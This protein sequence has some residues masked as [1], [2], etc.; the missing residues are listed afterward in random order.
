MHIS[1]MAIRYESVRLDLM[2][3]NIFEYGW[4]FSL[5]LM[6]VSASLYKKWKASGEVRRLSPWL[7]FSSIRGMTI[8]FVFA[9]FLTLWIA[10]TLYYQ[11]ATSAIHSAGTLLILISSFAFAVLVAD[12]VTKHV[13]SVVLKIQNQDGFQSA[14]EAPFIP[15]EIRIIT[16]HFEKLTT[17]IAAEKDQVLTL[18]SGVTH[19]LKGPLSAMQ[20]V[21]P[22]VSKAVGKDCG[23][24]R[25]IARAMTNIKDCVQLMQKTVDDLLKRRKVVVEGESIDEAVKKA[26]TLVQ[27]AHE[28]IPIIVETPIVI[29]GPRV[30]GLVRVLSNLI[31]NA[32]EASPAHEAVQVS[33][34]TSNEEYEIVVEDHGSGIPK[35]VLEMIERG[36]PVTTKKTGN[37]LGLTTMISWARKSGVRYKI[38]S[39]PGRG[40]RVALSIPP[41]SA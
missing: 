8:G 16:H 29:E 41:R 23:C 37:G 11:T 36:Q 12:F 14:H 20:R 39:Q 27:L 30:Q 3:M 6:A 18:T 22:L 38:T 26:A 15:E 35:Q 17:E 31:S 13:H 4:A 10:L 25:K 34:R 19:D 9:G 1:D 40:T 7:P 5:M 28:E 24:D 21:V 2:G 32:A 33:L